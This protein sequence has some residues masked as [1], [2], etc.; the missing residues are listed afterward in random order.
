MSSSIRSRRRED[1][2]RVTR[3]NA[4]VKMR[5]ARELGRLEFTKI[6]RVSGIRAPGA[7]G[8]LGGWEALSERV[9]GVIWGGGRRYLK[10]WE[11]VAAFEEW[12]GSVFP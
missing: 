10:G 2:A 1:R 7:P 6:V 4:R 8:S 5:I 12:T 11:A 9:G 3:L